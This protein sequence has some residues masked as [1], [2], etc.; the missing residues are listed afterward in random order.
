MKMVPN[1]AKDAFVVKNLQNVMHGIS[2]VDD[3]MDKRLPVK[4]QG[5]PSKSSTKRST[6]Q[7]YLTESNTATT[8]KRKFMDTFIHP[9]SRVIFK[10]TITLK[11]TK[12]FREFTETLMNLITNAQMIDPRFKKIE[13]IHYPTLQ[14]ISLW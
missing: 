13:E 1:R 6:D 7:V 9:H 11:M 5:G 8:Q 2:T 12:V 14:S 10:L 4:K 3:G